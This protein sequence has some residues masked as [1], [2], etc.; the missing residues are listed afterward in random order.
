MLAIKIF[1][2]RLNTSAGSLIS[3]LFISVVTVWTIWAAKTVIKCSSILLKYPTFAFF[4][5][6]KGKTNPKLEFLYFVFI[7]FV[8]F[9]FQQTYLFYIA[10]YVLKRTTNRITC[11][12]WHEKNISSFRA[13]TS[14]AKKKQKTCLSNRIR[15][16]TTT[17][18]GALTEL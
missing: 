8:F 16:H 14:W 6:F 9:K 18:Y 12:K 17:K 10:V 13:I 15:R 11:W 2:F 7:R 5:I 3:L 4:H 1:L